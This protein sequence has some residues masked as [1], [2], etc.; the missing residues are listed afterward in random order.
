MS[1]TCIA[2]VAAAL[3][4]P[5]GTVFAQAA[6]NSKSNVDPSKSTVSSRVADGQGNDRMDL[7]LTQQIRKSVLADKA[8]S[9]NAHNVKIVAVQGYVTLNGVVRSDA[10]K[11]SVEAKAVQIAGADKVKN[12]LEVAAP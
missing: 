11:A 5:A 10:E 3:L 12:R 2:F 9:I 1:N 7:R 6:D 4:A 8:L